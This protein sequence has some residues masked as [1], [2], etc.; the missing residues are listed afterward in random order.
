MEPLN[1]GGNETLFRED[2]MGTAK[3]YVTSV[4]ADKL[5]PFMRRPVED[6]IYETLDR[7]QTPSRK[8]FHELRDQI[9]T[10]KGKLT[11]TAGGVGK[12]KELIENIEDSIAD[13][14][15]QSSSESHGAQSEQIQSMEAQINALKATISALNEKITHQN[16]V[17]ESQNNALNSRLNTQESKIESLSTG[18]A[19]KVQSARTQTCKVPGC[20]EPVRAR[21]FCR[22]H[23][24]KWSRGTLDGFVTKDGIADGKKINKKHIALA[25]RIENGKI[26]V[27]DEAVASL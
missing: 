5:I 6:I 12:L 15:S 1:R 2:N 22:A 14:G 18:G 10:L 8:D 17:I 20:T 7:R 26:F 4:L 23:Y 9:N 21:G 19:V 25:Y 13:G 3:D 27:G 11:N 16:S 24:A